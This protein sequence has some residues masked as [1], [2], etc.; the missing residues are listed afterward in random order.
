MTILA[1]GA[2]AETMKARTK[3][4]T[5]ADHI[6]RLRAVVSA[7][8]ADPKRW[9]AADR[10]LLEPF[11]AL[12]AEAQALM[13]EEAR[14]DGLLSA[15]PQGV[16]TTSAERAKAA[17]FAKLDGELNA[18]ADSTGV[19]VPFA[20]KAAAPPAPAASRGFWKEASV[21]AASLLIGFFTVSQ[22]LLEGSGLDPAQ[23]T[24]SSVDDADDVSAIALGHADAEPSEE[25]LL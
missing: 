3:T 6:H 22:G 1:A 11:V 15:A 24:V 25:D 12:S 10:A 20:R 2:A 16:A 9:P 23:L 18:A 7:Y 14:F 8:G 17:L 4:M 19:V 13:A 5:T 21:M